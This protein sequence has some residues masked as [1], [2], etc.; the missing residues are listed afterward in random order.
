MRTCPGSIPRLLYIDSISTWTSNS[1]A[2]ATRFCPEIM[3]AIESEVKKLIDSGFIRK[4]QHP[5][6]VTN[7]VLV[8][9]KNGKIR[10][11]IDYCDLNDAYPKDEF[12]LPITNGVISNTC[13]FERMS[14]MDGFSGY[15]Q[16]KMYPKDEKHTSFRTHM[17]VYCY[18]VMPFNLKNAGA[19]Y[20]RAMNAIFHKHMR[21]TVECYVMTSLL[22]LIHI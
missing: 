10:I 13:D 21:K 14:F 18:T 2:I 19:T 9:K 20:Q 17:E 12:P 3:E 15:N 22:S 8:P 4:E 7:I 5:D 16:I 11:F 6:W 1:Q